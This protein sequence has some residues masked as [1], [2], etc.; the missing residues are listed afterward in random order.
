MSSKNNRLR[1]P[2]RGKHNSELWLVC[3]H[4]RDGS[5]AEVACRPDRIAVCKEC[6][7]RG[8]SKAPGDGGVTLEEVI[9]SCPA[10]LA[11]LLRKRPVPVYGREY[12]ERDGVL[13]HVGHN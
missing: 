4:V 2:T 1:R 8:P 3:V 11:D 10:C 6:A 9:T 5:A 13:G 12:L 7:T